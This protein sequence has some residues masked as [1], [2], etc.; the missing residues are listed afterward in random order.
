MDSTRGIKRMIWIRTF[1]IFGTTG[2]K[3]VIGSELSVVGPGFWPSLTLQDVVEFPDVTPIFGHVSQYECLQDVVRRSDWGFELGKLE[4]YVDSFMISM[5]INSKKTWFALSPPGLTQ[6]FSPTWMMC[7]LDFL[8]G[9][10]IFFWTK[11]ESWD[12]KNSL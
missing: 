1:P 3:Q 5:H 9:L 7:N 2:Y 6:W 4:F 12:V 11:S 8:G 10:N